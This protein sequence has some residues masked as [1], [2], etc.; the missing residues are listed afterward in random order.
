MSSNIGENRIELKT[1]GIVNCE[2]ERTEKSDVKVTPN[3]KHCQNNN[4]V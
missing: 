2:L 4:L 1:L 3:K